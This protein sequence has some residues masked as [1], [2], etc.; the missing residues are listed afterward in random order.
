MA[1]TQITLS[2]GNYGGEQVDSSLFNE[3]GR[4]TVT[5]ETGNG[6]VYDLNVSTDEGRADFVGMASA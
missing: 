1:S 3:A 2:G 5:D 6:W 4:Y